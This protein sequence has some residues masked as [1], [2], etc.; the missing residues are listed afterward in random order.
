MAGSRIARFITLAARGRT[1]GV[2]VG[3]RR[4]HESLE[5]RTRAFCEGI[6]SPKAFVA[7]DRTSIFVENRDRAPADHEA[8][9]ASDAVIEPRR[10]SKQIALTPRSDHKVV[11]EANRSPRIRGFAP[12]VHETSLKANS[13]PERNSSKS[14]ANRRSSANQACAPCCKAPDPFHFAIPHAPLG[15]RRS[16]GGHSQTS[17]YS[18]DLPIGW[19]PRRFQSLM[20]LTNERSF[21][22]CER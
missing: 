1:Y 21:I 20:A 14:L 3:Q 10:P 17:G 4:R 16:I 2:G 12:K 15:C 8:P 6:G 19:P 22:S 18:D 7:D 9:F 11:L 13:V 5:Y